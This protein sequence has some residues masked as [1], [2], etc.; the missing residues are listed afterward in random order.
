MYYIITFYLIT[1]NYFQLDFN[2]YSLKSDKSDNKRKS[3]NRR[4]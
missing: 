1:L 4:E 3:K 2:I